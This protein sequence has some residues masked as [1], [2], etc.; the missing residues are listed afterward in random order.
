MCP[1][2]CVLLFVARYGVLFHV[3]RCAAN[4]IKIPSGHVLRTAS[5]SISLCCLFCAPKQPFTNSGFSRNLSL[6][7]R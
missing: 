7:T 5:M 1:L 2:L 3:D 6:R 4:G